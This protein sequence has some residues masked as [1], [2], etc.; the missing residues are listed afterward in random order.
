MADKKHTS[1]ELRLTA[2]RYIPLGLD[3][4]YQYVMPDF[5]QRHSLPERFHSFNH[6][7]TNGY[8]KVGDCTVNG[9][10]AERF[11]NGEIGGIAIYFDRSNPLNVF[12]L[13]PEKIKLY[14]EMVYGP[15]VS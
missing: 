7:P 5:I 15:V 4:Y 12:G 8:K 2:D 6:L 13:I 9:T 3:E 1:Q 11:L 10:K 14:C